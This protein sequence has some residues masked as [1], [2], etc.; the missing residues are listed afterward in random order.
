M[1]DKRQRVYR[2]IGVF[3][4]L[5][6]AVLLLVSADILN[7]I[8]KGSL[9]ISKRLFSDDDELRIISSSENRVF[10][11]D[12]VSY[13]KQ[14]DLDIS[15][16]YED[17]L[18]I[19][20][21]LNSGEKY[22]AVWSSNSM[23]LSQI[24][25]SKATITDS[26][27]T[28]INPVVFGIKKSV[29]QKLG[30]IGK[31]I[32]TKE[33]IDKIA[34]KELKFAM[35]NPTSTN[36]GASAYFGILST[37]A[38]NPEVLTKDMLND[39]KLQEKLTTFFTGVER[40][41]G[42]E[43]FLEELFLS[44]DYEAVIT[45]E[46]SI[47]NINQKL[48]KSGKETL[49]AIYPIDGVSISD[50]TLSYIDNKSQVKKDSF[51]K[52]Q[53]YILSNEGQKLLQSYGRRTWYGGTTTTAD[54]KIFNPE[55]GIDTTKYIT[56]VKFPSLDVIEAALILY[57]EQLRKPVHVVFC[58]DYSGSMNGEGVKELTN[59]M[60]YILGDNAKKD[61]IQFSKK[62][63]IDIITF[64]TYVDD[65]W[66]VDDGTHTEQL[67]YKI[68]NKTPYGRTALYP[69][70]AEAIEVLQNEDR[71][72]YNLSVLVMTD[73]LAN[74]GTFYNLAQVYGN[75]K[76][77]VYSITFGDADENELD[78]ISNLTN[79]KTF[80]GKSGLVEAFKTV[81]GYN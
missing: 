17:T 15:I 26:K 67:L 65:R 38:G 74:E 47:I 49:Y 23:W 28:S 48:E 44:G 56:P 53:S 10:H 3:L 2:A 68:E 78:R 33:I 13:A 42:D 52:L 40:T 80:D 72:K 5:F 63:K 70:V 12:I 59:A 43:D 1:E 35:S 32:Y 21:L 4:I 29:A 9:E 25:S 7:I 71:E 24:D 61:F 19:V 6:S 45:Y 20:S 66:S 69:A 64:S 36:S 58:L 76:I 22:D 75:E 31:N 39:E 57:Q 77:P 16:V 34:S 18:D 60:K 30:F 73:G 81:R 8:D 62:D 11:D 79:G 14:N 37:L 50:S 46:S 41:S 27:S 55:W 51:L 54:A